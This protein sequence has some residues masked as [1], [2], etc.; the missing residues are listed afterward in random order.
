M[1]VTYGTVSG[2]KARD[3]VYYDFIS[4]MEG[5]MEKENPND[6]E[7]TVLPKLKELYEN[8]DFG[9]YADKNGKC[10]LDS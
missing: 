3:A 5:V 1:R 2:Y 10:L 6:R 4:Y 9:R 7:F 8:K